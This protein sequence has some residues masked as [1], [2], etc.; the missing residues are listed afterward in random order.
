MI[1]LAKDYKYH[2]WT[3]HID[4]RYHTIRQWVMNDKVIDLVKRSAEEESRGYDDE[5]HPSGEVQSI[6][7]LHQRSPKIKWKT[8]S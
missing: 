1:H 4:V 7:E 8:G 6:S 3:K 5:D 2:K